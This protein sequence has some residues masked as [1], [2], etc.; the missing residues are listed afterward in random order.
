M[1]AAAG[2]TG[3][4]RGGRCLQATGTYR[5]EKAISLIPLE[6]SPESVHNYDHQFGD[7]LGRFPGGGPITGLRNWASRESSRCTSFPGVSMPPLTDLRFGRRPCSRRAIEQGR[8]DPNSLAGRYSERTAGVEPVTGAVSTVRSDHDRRTR[9]HRRRAEASI[10]N[11]RAASEAA[12]NYRD[13]RVETSFLK[14]VENI[15]DEEEYLA[16]YNQTRSA[17]G[18]NWVALNLG[19]G[20]YDSSTNVHDVALRGRLEVY[21]DDEKARAE[22]VVGPRTLVGVPD[23]LETRPTHRTWKATVPA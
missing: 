21:A 16:L 4:T 3:T 23:S 7:V 11:G 1:D 14:D 8:D 13:F 10:S 5:W 15:S 17:H 19:S 12:F 2:R 22:A 9:R 18:F 20:E 6:I